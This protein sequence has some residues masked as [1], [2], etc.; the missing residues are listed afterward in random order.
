MPALGRG[1]AQ[2]LTEGT[3][4]GIFLVEKIAWAFPS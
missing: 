1:F 4:D 2:E 3:A